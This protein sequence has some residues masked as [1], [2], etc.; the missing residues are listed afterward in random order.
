MYTSIIYIYIHIYTHTYIYI[1]THTYAQA[2]PG[3]IAEAQV[4][5]L[6]IMLSG[7]LPGQVSIYPY[8][9]VRMYGYI[10]KYTQT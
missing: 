7:F 5:G 9:Y 8:M 1:S 6:P 2:G 3:T 4:I 10:C